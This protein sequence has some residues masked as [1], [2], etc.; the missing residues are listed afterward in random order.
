MTMKNWLAVGLVLALLGG[1]AA[2]MANAKKTSYETPAYT[3]KDT[4][5]AFEVRDYEPLVIAEVTTIGERKNAI[6]EGFRI[7]FGYIVGKNSTQTKLPMT[8]PVGQYGLSEDKDNDQWVT[9]FI[10]PKGY[11]Q[12]TL[13]KPTNTA[14]RFIE[15]PA[16]TWA[17]FQ[18]SGNPNTAQLKK[19]SDDLKAALKA[20]GLPTVMAGVPV[21]YAFYNPPFTLPFLRRNEVMIRV[22][23]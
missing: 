22:N 6:N 12:K 7:L 19:R 8:I 9:E 20:S 13:P 10:M 23:P 14:I 17:V 11:T 1:G 4:T 21:C 18:F 15:L 2:L 5:A 3:V 16:S